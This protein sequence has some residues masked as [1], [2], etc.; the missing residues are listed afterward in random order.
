MLYYGTRISENISTREPE[1][2][3]IPRG[4]IPSVHYSPN[5]DAARYAIDMPGYGRDCLCLRLRRVIRCVSVL[6]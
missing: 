6:S 3:L 2:F 5:P 4:K 1:G